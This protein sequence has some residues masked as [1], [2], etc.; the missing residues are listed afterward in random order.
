VTVKHRLVQVVSRTTFDALL[1]VAREPYRAMML[2]QWALGVRPGEVCKLRHA[3]V[4]FA[5]STLVT[6]IDGK[7]GERR[8]P[9]DPRGAAAIA[10]Q[11]WD[12]GRGE[13]DY[14]FGGE[15]AVKVSTYNQT[16]ARYSN[17]IGIARLR[18][19]ALRH[20]FASRLMHNG[21]AVADIAGLLGNAPDTCSKYYLHEDTENRR[22]MT[23]GC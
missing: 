12:D 1:G 8:L 18:P 21:E 22:R 6:P 13:R 3:D 20:T 14:F 5:D 15:T 23:A 11:S 16:L 4:D 9:F 2:V 10:M 17:R 7:S 19:Y